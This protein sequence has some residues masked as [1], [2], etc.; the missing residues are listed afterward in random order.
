VPDPVPFQPVSG[1]AQGLGA[2]PTGPGGA[3]GVV[4]PVRITPNLFQLAAQRLVSQ[5]SGD[6]ASAAARLVNSAEGFG[7]DLGL[8]HATIET[9]NGKARV[10][11]ACLPVLGSGRT[12]M[13][14]VSEPVATG[15]PGGEAVA[16]AERAACVRAACEFLGREKSQEVKVAQ[17]LPERKEQWSMQALVDAGFTNVGCLSYLRRSISDRT[18]S[19]AEPV[20][21][22]TGVTVVPLTGVDA[23]KWDSTLITALNRTYME[24]MD[25]PEL[26]GM[27]TTAD[28]LASHKAT[29][30]FDPALWWVFL[31]KGEP[32]G[33]L[34]LTRCPEQRTLEL[35][36][37]GL[38]PELR[39]KGLSHAALWMGI[40]AAKASCAGWTVACAVDLRNAP[41][42][43]VYGRLGFRSFSERTAMVRV[44]GA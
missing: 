35:V 6:L 23:E 8:I 1:Q 7:I 2:S 18:G 3:A 38:S 10:R 33:C 9:S 30:E 20:V 16:R 32:H 4:R 41:A 14:F 27:R 11:Q 44:I 25:C 19:V 42:L 5:S 39:G 31:L 43:K 40:Q 34:L 26:C 17:G 24:T 36:Y 29:G 13:I 37:L 21:W 22:P 28:I 12:A 15:E